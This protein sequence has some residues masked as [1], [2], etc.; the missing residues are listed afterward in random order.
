MLSLFRM[1][2]F[3]MFLGSCL[4][5][6]FFKIFANSSTYIFVPSM[7]VCIS[8]QKVFE[9][10]TMFAIMLASILG[11]MIGNRTYRASLPFL[12]SYFRQEIAPY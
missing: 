12:I 8:L 6:C 10:V 7:I 1:S 2:S 4:E 5:Y 11:S 9:L 3:F